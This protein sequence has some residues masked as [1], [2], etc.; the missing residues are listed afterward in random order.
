MCEHLDQLIQLEY[1][2]GPLKQVFQLETA[3]GAAIESFK[4]A[5]AVVV[6]RSLSSLSLCRS[7][8]E[9]PKK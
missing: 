9:R 1:S 3:M 6:D 2:L 5:G 8:L 4:G 7:L